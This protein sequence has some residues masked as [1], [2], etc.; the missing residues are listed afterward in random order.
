[1]GRAREPLLPLSKGLPA[2]R[3]LRQRPVAEPARDRANRAGPVPGVRLASEGL[4]AGPLLRPA[5]HRSAVADAADEVAL[6]RHAD[7]AADHV[8]RDPER[9]VGAP[10]LRR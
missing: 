5:L 4:A 2:R 8:R 10:A 1:A 9:Q 3:L 7:R 6:L